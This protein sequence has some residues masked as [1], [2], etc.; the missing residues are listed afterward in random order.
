MINLRFKSLLFIKIININ[1]KKTSVKFADGCVFLKN[2]QGYTISYTKI[3][4]NGLFGLF[5]ESFSARIYRGRC[6]FRNFY[7]RV[8]LSRF[9]K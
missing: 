7:W 6:F 8:L 5:V 3:E 1:N 2:A 9:S 4:I